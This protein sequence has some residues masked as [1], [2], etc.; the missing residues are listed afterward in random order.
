MDA[1]SVDQ[2]NV[3]AKGRNTSQNSCRSKKRSTTRRHFFPAA[4]WHHLDRERQEVDE[5]AQDSSWLRKS[6]KKLKRTEASTAFKQGGPRPTHSGPQGKLVPREFYA[7]IKD[8]ESSGKDLG[9]LVFAHRQSKAQQSMNRRGLV[10][11]L[12]PWKTARR[13]PRLYRTP[14]TKYRK[15]GCKEVTTCGSK[16]VPEIEIC[17]VCKNEGGGKEVTDRRP[18][19][20]G[21]KTKR[22]KTIHVFCCCKNL[23][24]IVAVV[25]VFCKN[26]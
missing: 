21:K 22:E 26:S 23:S 7:S 9:N 25:T 15:R 8:V 11:A 20:E 4:A 19:S 17:I 5:P 6:V 2:P 1:V 14:S 13:S 24:H 3:V 10:N 18:I 16:V 12:T